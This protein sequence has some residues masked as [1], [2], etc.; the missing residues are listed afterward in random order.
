MKVEYKAEGC[1]Y[2]STNYNNFSLENLFKFMSNRDDRIK[3]LT[4]R[5]N[6]LRLQRKEL[7]KKEKVVYKELKVLV[8][9]SAPARNTALPNEVKSG[10]SESEESDSDGDPNPPPLKEKAINKE[11]DLNLTVLDPKKKFKKGEALYIT[12]DISH[13]RERNG[14]RSIEHRLGKFHKETFGGRVYLDTRSGDRPWRLRKNLKSATIRYDI[15]N[16]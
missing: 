7:A 16:N 11:G 12:N 9:G 4:N 15:S 8:F 6:Y 2:N 3:E 13:F 10:E 14:K 1:V 5:L